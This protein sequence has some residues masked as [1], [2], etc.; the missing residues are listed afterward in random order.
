MPNRFWVGW[1][2]GTNTGVAIIDDEKNAQYFKLPVKSTVNYQKVKENITRIDV[3]A[4]KEKLKDLDPAKTI[5]LIER[6][7][8]NPGMFK[9]S[10]SGVRA[11]ESTLIVVEW[12]NLPYMFMDSKN[13]QG[14]MIPSGVHGKDLKKVSLEIGKRLFPNLEWKGFKDADSLLMAEY[15][16]RK[17]L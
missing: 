1:D 8:V 14:D 12:L 11:L 15:A 9:A 4:M 10:L 3:V 7:M 5:V 17:N 16:R 6:P 13:W 2:N